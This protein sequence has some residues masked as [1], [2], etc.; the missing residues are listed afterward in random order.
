MIIEGILDNLWEVKDSEDLSTVAIKN[1][2]EE[3]EINEQTD[4]LGFQSLP[5]RSGFKLG[6]SGGT[7]IYDGD[8]PRGAM[9]PMGEFSLGFFQDSKFSFDIGIGAG[10]LATRDFYYTYVQHSRLNVRYRMLN[11]YKSTPYI[12]AGG[13]FLLN[14]GENPFGEL[15]EGTT[16][17]NNGFANATIG[18]EFMPSERT[19]IDLSA[20]YYWLFNDYV[21]QMA[22]GRYNDFYWTVKLGINFYLG[23]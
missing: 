23:K 16:L 19:G 6:L 20:G 14:L 22:Q 3:K 11:H 13:G 21:D 15:P 2:L 5:Y 9:G 8:Y 17:N 7:M 18:Y 10:K 4:Y 1:Y 12:E